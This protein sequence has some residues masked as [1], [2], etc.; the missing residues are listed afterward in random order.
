MIVRSPEGLRCLVGVPAAHELDAAR[1][2]ALR[3]QY[4]SPGLV[5]LTLVR[6]SLDRPRLISF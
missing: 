1:E 2:A 4:Y 3:T 6:E 5:G